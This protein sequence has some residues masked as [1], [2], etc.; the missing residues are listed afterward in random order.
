MTKSLGALV[1]TY[2]GIGPQCLLNKSYM[3]TTNNLSIDITLCMS[4]QIKFVNFLPRKNVSLGSLQ[5]SCADTVG[6][7]L[8]V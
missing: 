3:S 4:I 7:K 5:L 1:R 8:F 2:A 6:R